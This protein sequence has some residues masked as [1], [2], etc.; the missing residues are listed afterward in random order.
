MHPHLQKT[1]VNARL[2]RLE[3]GEAIDWATAEA[4]AF[5]SLLLQGFDVRLSGQDVGR[6]TFSH[7]HAA[8][9]DQR[10]DELF[11][12]L[13]ALRPGQPGQLELANSPL[14]EEAVLAFEY[15]FSIEHPRRLVVWEAQFGDFYNTAQVEIDTLLAS[16]ECKSRGRD[17]TSPPQPSG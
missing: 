17:P 11:V 14:S 7:R 6:A 1:H 8:L 4:L 2:Q 10:T 3:Q 5:G 15:G 12:P 13:N 16:G 9:V